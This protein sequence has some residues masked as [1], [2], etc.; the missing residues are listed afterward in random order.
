MSQV[1]VL[2]VRGDSVYKSL[3]VDCWDIERDARLYSGPFPVVVHP[4][5]R[6]WGRLRHFAKPRLDEKALGLHAASMVRKYGGVLEHPA[7]STLFAAAGLPR[8]GC[9]VDDFGGWSIQVPQF[10]WGHRA[11]KSTWLYVVG[12]APGSIPRFPLVLGD[13]PCTVGLYSGRDRATCRKEISK[14]ERE[15]TP[16][17]FARWLIDLGS[18]CTK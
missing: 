5:C 18:R 8:P 3:G 11:Y 16:V 1:A 6:A 17:D 13:A 15:A 9:G 10:W 7:A 12:C 14:K 2:Y 4:P